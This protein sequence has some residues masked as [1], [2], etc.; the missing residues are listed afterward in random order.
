MI[1]QYKLVVFGELMSS[2]NSK[3]IFKN[4]KTGNMFIAKSKQAMFSEREIMAELVQSKPEW[5]QYIKPHLKFP[6]KIKFKI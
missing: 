2:K 3:Q 1:T 4:R 6:Q 5:D